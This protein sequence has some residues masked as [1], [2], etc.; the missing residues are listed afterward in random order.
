MRHI[1][2]STQTKSTYPL[3]ILSTVLHI[4]SME[5]AF[6]KP[7]GVD[8]EQ[9]VALELHKTGKKT[10]QSEMKEFSQDLVSALAQMGSQY[11]IVT[12]ADYF[13]ILS[14]QNKAEANIGYV[15]KS[16]LGDFFVTYAPSHKQVFYDPDKT[17]PKIA[18]CL[19]AIDEH[20]SGLYQPPGHGL[21]KRACYP[22][23]EQALINELQNLFNLDQ[24]VTCDIEG[25]SLKHY[26]AGL[27]TI[28]FAINE[29]EGFAFKVD[30]AGHT[31]PPARTR[32][33]LRDFFIHFPRKIIFHNAS[34]DLTVLIYQLFMDHI[35]DTSGLLFGLEV[36]M[37]K[38]EDTK[39]IAFLATN[40]CAGNKNSL[41]ELAQEFAGNYAM[42]EI[43]DITKIDEDKLLEYNLVDTLSTWFVYNKYYPI[44]VA[45]DQEQVYRELF[46]PC[47]ADI[48]QMQLTGMPLDMNKVAQARKILQADYDGAISAL[49]LVHYITQ[50]DQVLMQRTEDE[51]LADWQARKAA[52]VK[53]RPYVP[54][55]M[56]SEFNPNSGPQLQELLYNYLGLP[57]LDKTDTGLP[58]TGKETFKKLKN[59]T[60]DPMI[61]AILDALIIVKDVGIILTT[62]IPAFERAVQGPS[63][64]WYLF[65]FFNLGGTVSGRL[66]SNGPNLQNIPAN[67]KYAKVIKQCFV[68]MEGWLFVGLDFASLEDRISALTTKD[69]NKLKVYTDGYDGHS[70]RAYS[71]FGEQ[72]P[73]IDPTSVASINSIEKLYK[74]LRQDSKTP[75]FLLTYGGTYMGIMDQMG[76]TERKAREVETR[77]HEMYV[78]SDM[79]VQAKLDQAGK[80]GFVRVAFGLKVRTPLLRQVI[81]GTR[82]TPFEA[83]AEGRTAGNALGQSWGLLN[84]RAV[85]AFMQKVRAHPKYRTWIRPCAQIHDANYYL[86]KDDPELVLWMNENLVQEVKWQDHPDIWHDEVKLGGE[87]SIFWPSWAEECK[88]ENELDL[89]GLWETVA[90]HHVNLAEAEAKKKQAA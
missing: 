51:R 57:V 44:M 60:Q 38:V 73:D 7:H 81:R 79:W 58:A 3:C 23:T 78:H 64:Q 74:P 75:T 33:I 65:G 46:R 43:S 24:D 12:D 83:E 42:S 26:D 61:Q 63:G 90:Q 71:Y 5:D 68:M 55:K 76:W 25:Y 20:A 27:G 53:V 8:P 34:F 56:A 89:D 62:F 59:H 11:V 49:N 35:E 54:G 30:L 29:N 85:M 82:V 70:L 37:E 48:I 32:E 18:R 52:G 45:E 86:I 28:S 50:F 10:P 1:L 40:S 2:F 66:S 9:V 22:T 87:L 84:S 39:L 13:K 15:H 69:P 6:I 72:M 41:K 19:Q 36:F 80:D 21:I 88:L 14:G 77:Y 67:S 16:P 47:L 4:K 17:K 31:I